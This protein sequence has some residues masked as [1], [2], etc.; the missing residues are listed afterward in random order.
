MAGSSAGVLVPP[1]M[2]RELEIMLSKIVKGE[3]EVP[4]AT[5]LTGVAPEETGV[6]AGKASQKRK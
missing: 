6:P 4:V 5:L 2:K 1:T 3:L